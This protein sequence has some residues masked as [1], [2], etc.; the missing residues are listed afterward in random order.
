[1]SINPCDGADSFGCPPCFFI[2]R[3]GLKEHF[4]NSSVL[5]CSRNGYD[6]F[7][8]SSNISVNLLC[9]L[10][11]T[12]K[13]L[14][15]RLCGFA[16]DLIL[17]KFFISIAIQN[18]AV[19][20]A[21]NH[22]LGW[23]WSSPISDGNPNRSVCRRIRMFE[24]YVLFIPGLPPEVANAF[25]TSFNVGIICRRKPNQLSRFS[26]VSFNSLCLKIY[27]LPLRQLNWHS[28]LV[29][30]LICLL[31]KYINQSSRSG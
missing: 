13:W 16:L 8:P 9:Y 2:M 30:R 17:C 31:K 22:L 5:I 23:Y 20:T 25:E 12:G 1:M 19:S 15:T 10:M 18:I 28:F 24:G 14:F 21:D 27:A 6:R 3:R 29:T 26:W 11:S 7:F 4:S